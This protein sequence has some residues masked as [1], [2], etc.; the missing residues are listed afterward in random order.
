MAR[1]LYFDCFS[2]ISGDMVL[3]AFL[4]AGLPFDDLKRALGSLAMPGYDITAER[5]L[6]AG[7]SA[8]RFSVNEHGSHHEHAAAHGHDDS[9]EHEHDHGHTHDHREGHSHTHEHGEDHGHSRSHAHNGHDHRTLPEIFELID[10]SAL[11]A[12]GRNR[13]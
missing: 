8:T 9:H 1:V 7:V 6:R 11:S 3:G 5:V 12:S 10:R 4:D 2:G 13:A